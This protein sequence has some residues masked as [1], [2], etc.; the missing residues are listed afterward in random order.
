MRWTRSKPTSIDSS[1]DNPDR[2]VPHA[3][4]LALQLPESVTHVL[5]FN[6]HIVIGRDHL[7]QMQA[8]SRLESKHERLAGLGCRVVGD[9]STKNTVESIID[10]T[11]SSPLGGGTGQFAQFNVEGKPTFP[12][13]HCICVLHWKTL[14]V[15]MNRF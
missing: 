4:N 10:A 2:F 13:L 7:V 15:G 9:D 14:A 6:G 8:W 1:L 12:L 11:L 3:R 5:E